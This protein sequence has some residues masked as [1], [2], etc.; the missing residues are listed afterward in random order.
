MP[1]RTVLALCWNDI[2]N[3]LLRALFQV[4]NK[5]SVKTEVDFSSKTL[6]LLMFDFFFVIPF[7][8]YSHN[9]SKFAKV[10]FMSG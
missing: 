1:C 10:F 4:A 5:V 9:L 2:V 3:F 6:W 8:F 7:K